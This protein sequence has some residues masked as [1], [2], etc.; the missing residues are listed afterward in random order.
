MAINKKKED[1]NLLGV[2]T[3]I[4]LILVSTAL[5]VWALPGQTESRL[6]YEV[7]RPWIGSALIADCNYDVMR[8]DST[9]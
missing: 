2:F 6:Y 5:I 9:I 3:R 8:A 4:V 1:R 7:G